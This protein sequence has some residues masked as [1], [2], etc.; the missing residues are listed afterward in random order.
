MLRSPPKLR[1]DELIGTTQDKG[2]TTKLLPQWHGP[3]RV[4]QK[5]SDVNYE[6]TKWEDVVKQM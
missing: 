2:L 6:L 4:T 1:E 3:W 5:L